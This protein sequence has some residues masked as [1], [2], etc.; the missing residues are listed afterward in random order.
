MCNN[1]VQDNSNVR[2]SAV[3]EIQTGSCSLDSTH[4]AYGSD[5][6]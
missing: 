2:S 3:T 6:W 4:S 1:I 5:A